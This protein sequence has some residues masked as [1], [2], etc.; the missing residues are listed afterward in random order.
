MPQRIGRA[1]S[2]TLAGVVVSGVQLIYYRFIDH[3]DG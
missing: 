1:R 2:R 3:A